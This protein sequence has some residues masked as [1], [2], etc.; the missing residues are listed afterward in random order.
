M[1]ILLKALE[2]LNRKYFT[3]NTLFYSLQFF[4]NEKIIIN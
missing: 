3:N 2:F 1:L 4:E